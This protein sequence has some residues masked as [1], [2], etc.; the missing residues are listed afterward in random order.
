MHPVCPRNME[1]SK[2][3]RSAG[4]AR[5]TFIDASPDKRWWFHK[6]FLLLPLMFS[7]GLKPLPLDW[8]VLVYTQGD[9]R[10]NSFR[11][12]VN[13]NMN[14]V[15]RDISQLPANRLPQFIF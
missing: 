8:L 10:S 5:A 4:W 15:L 12:R 1:M 14:G 7:Y 11:Y 3:L 2:N 13:V 9:R 6:P